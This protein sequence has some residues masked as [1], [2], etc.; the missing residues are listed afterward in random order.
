M[1]GSV[2]I[3]EGQFLRV[4]TREP[5]KVTFLFW[6]VALTVGLVA[7]LPGAAGA[8]KVSTEAALRKAWDN[9]RTTKIRLTRDIALRACGEGDPIR[10]IGDGHL[11]AGHAGDVWFPQPAPEDHPW[12]TM[13]HH[14]MTPHVSGS[15]LSAQTRYA[16]GT[17]EILECWLDGTPIREEYLIVDGG[18]LAGTGAHSYSAGNAT[19]GSEEAARFGKT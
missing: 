4:A 7:A 12:R 11:I 17:R 15:S 13:P 8:A 14:G 16:A 2:C 5:R 10:V 19:A 6:A 1:S 9:P 3:Q 18:A